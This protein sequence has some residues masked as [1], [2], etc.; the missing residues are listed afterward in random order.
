MSCTKFEHFLL[1][2]PKALPSGLIIFCKSSYKIFLELKYETFANNTF[3]VGLVDSFPKI[4]E[5]PEHL[6]HINLWC[7]PEGYQVYDSF[8][9]VINKGDTI[10]S[11]S[12][13]IL[14]NIREEM[15]NFYEI[16]HFIL[17]DKNYVKR[18]CSSLI[19]YV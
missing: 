3:E 7:F 18:Y 10:K 6:D 14:P 13:K 1:L 16:N 12:N 15:A 4:S 8:K 2:G 9:N 11:R 17:T 19:F 5:L